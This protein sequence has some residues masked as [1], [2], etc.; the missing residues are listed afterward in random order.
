MLFRSA[1]SSSSSSI[2]LE[3]PSPSKASRSGSAA[4]RTPAR[5][6]SATH[7]YRAAHAGKWA[8]A[9]SRPKE[10]H[11]RRRTPP[12][13]KAAPATPSS[14]TRR[15]QATHSHHSYVQARSGVSPPSRRRG[16]RRREGKPA[17]HRRRAWSNGGFQISPLL[18]VAG[19]SRVQ[20]PVTLTRSCRFVLQEEF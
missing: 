3:S 14:P 9:R 16:G 18:T 7:L 10:R 5:E 20:G 6:A 1:S 2:W 11:H 12:T 4:P 13:Q 15:R 17:I 8:G 19:K